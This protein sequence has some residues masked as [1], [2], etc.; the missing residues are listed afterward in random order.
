MGQPINTATAEENRIRSAYAKREEDDFRYSY[1]N[2]GHLLMVQQRERRL[3][4]LLSQRGLADLDRRMILEVGCGTG[5]WLRDFVKWGARP[6]KIT[7]IDLLP[8]RV[9][10]A[11][12]LCPPGVRIQCA[13]A[14]EVPFESEEFDIVLQ[15]TVFTSIID[16][17]LKRRIA[18]EM[19]RVVKPEGV[20]VWYDYHVNNPWN[21]DVRGIK[22]REIGTLFPGCRIELQRITLLPPLARRLAPYSFL[23]CYF[24]EKVPLLCTHYL[25]IIR[26]TI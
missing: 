17:D 25:G 24:L 23:T 6:E 21:P 3:L 14:A 15:S 10:K 22:R 8:D 5:Q 1:F 12:Q 11:Q 18:A 9:S 7:G 20:I 2:P 16:R 19:M 13:S 4:G 26:K